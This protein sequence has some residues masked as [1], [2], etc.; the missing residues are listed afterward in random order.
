MR[1][2]CTEEKRE[3]VQRGEKAGRKSDRKAA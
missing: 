3:T 2:R 1:K